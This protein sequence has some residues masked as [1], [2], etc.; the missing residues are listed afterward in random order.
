MELEALLAFAAAAAVSGVL[1][2]LTARLA[3]RVGAV[4]E[5]R[6]RGLANRP[7]PR[8]GGLAILAGVLV[9]GAVFLP[10]GPEWRAILGGAAAI[11]LI[12][13]VDDRYRLPAGV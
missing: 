4:D 7:M 8:L 12:G 6:D 2:P 11:T 10:A 1:T 9:A 13:A 5:P 3:W